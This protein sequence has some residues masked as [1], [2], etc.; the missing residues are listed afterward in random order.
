VDQYLYQATP[1][2]IGDVVRLKSGAPPSM[3]VIF[4]NG[5]E[6]VTC[7]GTKSGA[8]RRDKFPAAALE[9]S[10]GKINLFDGSQFYEDREPVN[11]TEEAPN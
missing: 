4:I 9:I 6:I 7:W 5:D 1:F 2:T 11:S 8:V 3:T 10:H